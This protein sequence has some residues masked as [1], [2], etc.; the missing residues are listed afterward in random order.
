MV[1]MA[2]RVVKH[3][4]PP[5]FWVSPFTS[6]SLTPWLPWCSLGNRYGLSRLT[7]EAEGAYDRKQQLPLR[8]PGQNRSFWVWGLPGSFHSLLLPYYRTSRPLLHPS[9]F[10]QL[11]HCL[12]LILSAP[13]HLS[14]IRHQGNDINKAAEDGRERGSLWRL[15]KASLLL[16]PSWIFCGEE[17]K[18]LIFLKL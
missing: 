2:S 13:G 16:H 9:V 18:H 15:F 6:P 7:A 5:S 12:C 14:S 8:R 1:E 17:A 3:W 10:L 4:I 11:T